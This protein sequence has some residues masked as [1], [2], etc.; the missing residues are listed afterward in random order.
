VL[1]LVACSG[2]FR[3]RINTTYLLRDF[4]KDTVNKSCVGLKVL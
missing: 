2:W 4:C 1:L 3:L